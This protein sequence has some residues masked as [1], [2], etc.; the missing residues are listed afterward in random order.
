MQDTL[1]VHGGYYT[2]LIGADDTPL[3]VLDVVSAKRGWSSSWPGASRVRGSW[4]GLVV[5][6][7]LRGGFQTNRV[8]MFRLNW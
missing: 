5:G 3:H 2:I 6:G 8:V 1:T 4:G 7:L